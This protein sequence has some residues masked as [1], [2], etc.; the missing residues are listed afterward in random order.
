MRIFPHHNHKAY[1]IK[2]DILYYSNY[3]PNSKKVLGIISK[4]GLTEKM[5]CINI[6]KRKRDP[7]TGHVY[8]QMENGKNVMM[9]PNVHGVPALLKVNDKYSAIF[10]GEIISYLEPQIK[11]NISQMVQINGEP[12]GTSLGQSIGGVSIVSEQFTYFNAPPEELSAKGNGSARQMYN[13]VSA[14]HTQNHTIQTPPDSYKPD[15]I[16]EAVNVESLQNQR[17]QDIPQTGPPN[18]YGI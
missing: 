3:C 4:H 5:N 6:D 8:I 17:N 2:M 10:G 1:S 13:Y 18:P 9:P 14:D 11:A 12:V 7:Q 16:G 15:K